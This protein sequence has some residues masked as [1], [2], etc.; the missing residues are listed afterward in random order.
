REEDAPRAED[1]PHLGE[2]ARAVGAEDAMEEVV[3]DRRVEGADSGE[4]EDVASLEADVREAVFERVLPRELDRRLGVVHSEHGAAA[5]REAES[6]L[7]AAAA[8]VEDARSSHGSPRRVEE[9]VEGAVGALVH[10][11]PEVV[12]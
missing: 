10:S 1:A 3:V 6:R 7:T 4:R 8:E 2:D 9:R 5:A 11:G 12:P